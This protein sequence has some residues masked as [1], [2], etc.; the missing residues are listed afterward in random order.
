MEQ[1]HFYWRP[2]NLA[3]SGYHNLDK[4]SR[5]EF[6]FNHFEVNQGICSKTHLI[7]SLHNYYAQ[8][9]PAVKENYGT[10]DSTPTTFVVAKA[11]DEREVHAFLQRFREIAAGG[12]RFE[13]VPVKHCKQNMWVCKPASL[14]QG[15]GI[16]IFKQS[17]EITD[18]VFGKKD[19]LCV[20]QKYIEKPLLYK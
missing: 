4:H 12:S 8:H 5:T 1:A 18:F 10:F 3:Y 20:V 6:I 19:S 14:N 7:R 9:E 2:V 11:A 13:R 17:K 16:E 15:K